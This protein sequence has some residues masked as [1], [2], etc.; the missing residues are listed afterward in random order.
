MYQRGFKVFEW[1]NDAGKI[2]TKNGLI[3][4]ALQTLPTTQREEARRLIRSVIQEVLASLL[5]CPISE[6]R[7]LSKTGQ[8]IMFLNENHDIGLSISHESRLSLV[9]INMKG[10]VG[11]DLMSMESIPDYEELQMIANEYLSEKVGGSIFRQPLESQKETFAHAWTAF[12]ASLKLKGEALIEW[13]A[14]RD[15]MLDN[16]HTFNLDLTD[17]YIGSL[18]FEI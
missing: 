4:I 12:E 5:N 1:P 13:S 14:K 8:A 11:V 9:A 7:L 3:V 2:Y 6:I 10:R 18:A 17:G 15:E 16:V